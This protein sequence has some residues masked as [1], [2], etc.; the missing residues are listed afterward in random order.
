[1]EWLPRPMGSADV[2]AA[3]I[4]CPLKGK[5][6]KKFIK[7]T[8][9]K[10]RR[11]QRA[12]DRKL[13][14]PVPSEEQLRAEEAELEAREREAEEQLLKDLARWREREAVLEAR[15]QEIRRALNAQMN[16]T[17]LT[18]PRDQPPEVND[19]EGQ[20]QQ[21]PPKAPRPPPPAPEQR[22]RQQPAPPPFDI[23]DP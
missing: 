19:S 3:I 14:L 6:R 20:T 1:M 23:P 2:K 7:H 22:V 21:T 8:R 4:S 5:P 13:A 9:R 11:Q 16:E 12:Y 18:P 17:A 15:S 10:R